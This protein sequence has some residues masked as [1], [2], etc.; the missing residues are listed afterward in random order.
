MTSL[1]RGRL[2][3]LW[4]RVQLVGGWACA[5]VGDRVARVARRWRTASMPRR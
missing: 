1:A 2:R 3:M 4:R 5:V